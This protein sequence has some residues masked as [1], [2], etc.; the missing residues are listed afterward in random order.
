VGLRYSKDT[1]KRNIQPGKIMKKLVYAGGYMQDDELPDLFYKFQRL[2]HSSILVAGATPLP[3]SRGSDFHTP[4]Y[5][6]PVWKG[7]N[8]ITFAD[9]T[10]LKT[11]EIIAYAETNDLPIVVLWS[12]GID[13]TLVLAAIIKHFSKEM[14]DRVVIRMTNASYTEN[15]YFFNTYIK[16][17]L[18]HGSFRD[19][20]YD[21]TNAII[22][23][24]DP[25]DAIWLGG[26]ILNICAQS[27]GAQD[28]GITEGKDVLLQF[29]TKRSDADYSE[30][31]YNYLIEESSA[32]GFELHTINDWFWWL[33][34]NYNYGTMCIKHLSETAQPLTS[35]LVPLYFTNFI[36]WFHSDEY[37]IWSIQAQ[38]AGEKFDGSI[39][40]YKM[41]AKEYIYEFDKNQ[42]Y[43]DYKTKI[44]SQYITQFKAGV[45]DAVYEDWEIVLS[46]TP[47]HC[48]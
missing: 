20:L 3:R 34:F 7:L 1:S 39:R 25:A 5:P 43:R 30:W 23:H 21:Y 19:E 13:S 2:P 9:A 28:L 45:I 11:Q 41:L 47:G 16:D 38:Q 27:P 42:W 24:G 37:Q 10:D 6:I 29:L 48:L 44:H 31:L 15:P 33:I 18:Q 17:K 46:D 40:S 14:L 22:L 36:P 26:N 8:K 32:A 35:D 12:G 4:L